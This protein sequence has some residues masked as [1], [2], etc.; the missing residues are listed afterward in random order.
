MYGK[1]PYMGKTRID[2]RR[3][4]LVQTEEVESF[5]EKIVT[6]FGRV[7]A[8][9]DCPSKF[10]GRRVIVVVCKEWEAR[11]IL[12]RGARLQSIF[13]RR[14]E[15]LRSRE[16]PTRPSGPRP[17]AARGTTRPR[18]TSSRRRWGLIGTMAEK[19]SVAFR[20]PPRCDAVGRGPYSN[21]GAARLVL[22]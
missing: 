20:L 3:D 7:R 2:V 10:V 22:A 21:R 13:E 4:H 16:F 18:R 1:Y 6:K 12:P 8:K 19:A 15:D 17:G 11:P 9:I 5:F 14:V